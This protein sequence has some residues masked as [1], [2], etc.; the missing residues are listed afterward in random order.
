MSFISNITSAASGPV[1]AGIGAAVVAG[2]GAAFVASHVGAR[3]LAIPDG[4]SIHELDVGTV[5]EDGSTAVASTRPTPHSRKKSVDDYLESI[6]PRSIFDSTK[7]GIVTTAAPSDGTERKTDLKVVLLATLV[8]EPAEFSSALIA[9]ERGSDGAVGY[10]IG[11]KLLG[12]GVVESITPKKVYIRRNDKSLE[13]IELEGG[14]YE[15]TGE[16]KGKGGKAAEE[17]G[18]T[19][20][21]PN[22]FIVDQAVV[23]EL[24]KNPEQLYSQVRAVPH[25]G[26]DGQV[27]GYRLSGIRRRSFFYKLGVKNGD[28]IHS[29]NGKSLDSMGNAMS[30]YESLASD[31][32]FNFEVTRRNSKQTFEYEI[33]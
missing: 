17:D 8:A 23:D 19:K 9:E 15:K 31:K 12:E 1:I 18:V 20:E 2:W 25:K 30:A 27:D 14:K 16:K 5:A 10:G 22:K 11:D 4:K 13:F 33:R 24:L 3:M 28:I 26:A 7:V 29:V 32:N 21:G 6:V